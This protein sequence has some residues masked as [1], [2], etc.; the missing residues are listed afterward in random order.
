M[1][2]ENEDED[3]LMLAVE[4]GPAWNIWMQTI[5]GASHQQARGTEGVHAT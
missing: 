1:C 4:S 2:T 5:L 3:T